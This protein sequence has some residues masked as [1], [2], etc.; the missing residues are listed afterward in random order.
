V[1][2]IGYS[3]FYYDAYGLCGETLWFWF[4]RT[5]SFAGIAQGSNA[6]GLGYPKDASELE[7]SASAK[8]SVI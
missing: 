6:T 4:S 8:N 3:G 1:L 7:E 5:R 2:R